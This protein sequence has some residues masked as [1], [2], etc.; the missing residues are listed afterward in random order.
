M[1]FSPREVFAS[2]VVSA[3]ILGLTSVSSAQAGGVACRCE[4]LLSKLDPILI[5]EELKGTNFPD[6]AIAAIRNGQ[7]P[8]TAL[9]FLKYG[10]ILA[11]AEGGP[12]Q[13][14]EGPAGRVRL[15][16]LS[17]TSPRFLESLHVT[18]DY[19][20]AFATHSHHPDQ[21]IAA[22]V[23]WD[24]RLQS[25][26]RTEEKWA[27]QSEIGDFSDWWIKSATFSPDGATLATGSDGVH[28]WSIQDGKLRQEQAL[29]GTS[30][31]VS[32]IAFSLDGK[33]LM[34]GTGSSHF[35][36]EDGELLVWSLEKSPPTVIARASV[37]EGDV[38]AIV[39][40][41]TGRIITADQ[42]GDLVF[43]TLGQAGELTRIRKIHA[44]EKGVRSMDDVLGN[45]LISAGNDGTVALWDAETGQ[46]IK[47][48]TFQTNAAIVTVAPSGKH[49]AVGLT[50]GRVY[51]LRLP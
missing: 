29:L 14:G 35:A 8:I 6:E 27:R 18:T 10:Q 51:V 50:D 3:A 22:S 25:W 4:F 26:T 1:R 23:R 46:L 19:V 40:L 42:T 9:A 41:R 36:P 11:V 24:Q 33:Q 17:G 47:R 31:A 2:I 5:P 39:S 7:R 37:A 32:A 13:K 16:D 30:W 12:L 48:W 49:V 44:H 45:R 38:T 15:Y 28:L 34:A 21:L 20:S 43:W